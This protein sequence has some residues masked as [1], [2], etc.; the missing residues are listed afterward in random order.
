MTLDPATLWWI[1]VALTAIGTLAIAPV[2]IGYGRSGEAAIAV[3]AAL[4]L[5]P[6]ALLGIVPWYRRL[7]GRARPRRSDSTVPQ[8]GNT[9]V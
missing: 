7:P 6:I 4:C 2:P 9:G 5:G 8:G 3:W 1:S